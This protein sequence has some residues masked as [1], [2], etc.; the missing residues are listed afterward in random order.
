MTDKKPSGFDAVAMGPTASEAG[1]EEAGH[2][3]AD[4]SGHPSVKALFERFGD[5]VH[6]H[7][8]MPGNRHHSDQHVVFVRPEA[9]YQ[10]LEWLK[11]DPDHHYEFLCDVERS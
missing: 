4:P 5:A 6:R 11:T 9:A 7:E 3:G 10:A 1:Q 2:A 8:V